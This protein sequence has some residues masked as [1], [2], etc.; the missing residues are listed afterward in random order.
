MERQSGAGNWEAWI[1]DTRDN[2]LYRIVKMPDDNW[3]LAQNV[4]YK[5]TGIGNPYNGCT[6]ALCGRLYTGAQMSSTYTGS[7]GT[8]GY[9]ANKQGVCPNNWTL[10]VFATWRAF[11]DAIETVSNW[12]YYNNVD[13]FTFIYGCSNTISLKL[14]SEKNGTVSG[15]NHYGWN[16]DGLASKINNGYENWRG[17]D[18][19]NND[20]G[21]LIAYQLNIKR[22]DCVDIV[23]S[24]ST[25]DDA[26]PVRCFRQL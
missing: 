9:G 19:K 10:P 25:R 20:L 15:N 1:K 5:G 4:R 12:Y 2:E 26:A 11:V 24:T 3:W 17:N 22:A 16:I 8:S 7:I 6:D 13:G 14:A 23:S 21:L 18:K